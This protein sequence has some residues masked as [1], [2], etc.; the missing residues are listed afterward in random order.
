MVYTPGSAEPGSLDVA[1]GVVYSLPFAGF[2]CIQ[3]AVAAAR[4]A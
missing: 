3:S 1:E 2:I 4:G